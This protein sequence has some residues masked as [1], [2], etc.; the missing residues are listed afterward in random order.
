MGAFSNSKVR[1]PSGLRPEAPVAA[2]ASATVAAA[3]AWEIYRR[4]L[5]PGRLEVYETGLIEIGY[6]GL[7]ASVSVLGTLRGRDRDLF[8]RSINLRIV[9]GRDRAQHDFEWAAFRPFVIAPDPRSIPLEMPAGFM[10]RTSDPR[11]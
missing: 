5:R 1:A 3:S 10:I 7:G 2:V 8:V 4:Y 9:K 11:R 6:G